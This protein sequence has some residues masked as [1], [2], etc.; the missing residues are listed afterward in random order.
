ML[1]LAE[2]IRRRSVEPSRR[3]QLP[4]LNPTFFMMTRRG[5]FV[6]MAAA[7]LPKKKAMDTNGKFLFGGNIVVSTPRTG[8]KLYVAHMDN[9]P[10][11]SGGSF[12]G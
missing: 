1:G 9:V 6:L 7:F 3:V 8:F 10:I 12:S 4:Y 2:R 5:L 11:K